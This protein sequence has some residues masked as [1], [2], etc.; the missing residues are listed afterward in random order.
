MALSAS[1]ASTT[2]KPASL[3]ASAV[4]M[5]IRN[6]S[7]TMRITGCWGASAATMTNLMGAGWLRREEAELLFQA[8]ESMQRIEDRARRLKLMV[9][10]SSEEQGPP[11]GQVTCP[12]CLVL[13]SRISLGS[14]DPQTGL[15]T[16]TY[17]CPKCETQTSR[18][19][20]E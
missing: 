17:R 7:S 3:M 6:S 18:W 16:A 14:A 10:R 1:V 12:N 19:I 15:Q 11:I 2:S 4:A 20:K 5:R 13:M 9:D 8:L